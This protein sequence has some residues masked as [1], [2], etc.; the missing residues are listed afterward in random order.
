[1]SSQRDIGIGS[2]IA[3]QLYKQEKYYLYAKKQKLC[4]YFHF[5]KEEKAF[6]D[7]EHFAFV[8]VSKPAKHHTAMRFWLKAYVLH[9]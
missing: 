4:F 6:D 8:W 2:Q 3:I 7:T 1:L 5:K 9:N